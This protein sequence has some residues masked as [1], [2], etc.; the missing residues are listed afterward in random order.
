MKKLFF[1]LILNSCY[2]YVEPS[3]FIPDPEYKLAVA[4][5]ND[6]TLSSE[7]APACVHKAH[8]LC[9]EGFTTVKHTPMWHDAPAWMLIKCGK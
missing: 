1:V 9:P 4:T 5:C 8:M 6:S 3:G 2:S 7:P